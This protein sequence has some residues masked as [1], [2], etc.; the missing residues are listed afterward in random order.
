MK[1][2]PFNREE[3]QAEIDKY[4]ETIAQIRGERPEV[5][6]G[7]PYEIRMNMFLIKCSDIN[8]ALCDDCEELMKMILDKVGEHVFQIMAPKISQDVK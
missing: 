5:T 8:N 1:K 6:Q 7:M 2:E 3:F 4:Q